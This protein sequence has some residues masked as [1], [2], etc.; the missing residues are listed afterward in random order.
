M[1]N[2]L[3]SKCG[4]VPYSLVFVVLFSSCT[5]VEQLGSRDK[6]EAG[7][8]TALVQEPDVV[9]EKQ[10]LSQL[11]LES[12]NQW[13]AGI[14]GFAEN[15]L[16][17]FTGEYRVP[18]KTGTVRIWLTREF[19]YY[20][21]WD[22]RNS[23]TTRTVYQKRGNGSLVAAASL[24]NTWTLVILFPPGT[25]FTPEEEDRLI[26]VLVNKFADFSGQGQNISLPAL[27]P[28]S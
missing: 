23:I 8:I 2:R 9:E 25:E 22:A 10:E 5:P 7:P 21:G 26:M 27:I 12:G 13:T 6:K 11:A 28:I 16:S 20:E 1:N 15:A 14:P 4:L 24:N 17:A 19:I 3:S 18:A